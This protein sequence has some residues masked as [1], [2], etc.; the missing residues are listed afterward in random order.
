[1]TKLAQRLHIDAE[2]RCWDVTI[3]VVETRFKP[4]PPMVN[5][6]SFRMDAHDV[7]RVRPN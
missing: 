1:M 7:C 4:I 2:P 5:P 6:L 3:E